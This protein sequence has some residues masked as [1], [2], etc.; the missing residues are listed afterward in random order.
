MD[1]LTEYC[2][3]HDVSVIGLTETWLRNEV[4]DEEVCI[5]GFNIFRSDRK[6]RTNPDFPHGGV[7]FYVKEDLLVEHVSKFT[8]GVC[9]ALVM[10]IRNHDV[11]LGVVYRPP[12]TLPAVFQEAASFITE[13]FEAMSTTSPVSTTLLMG[14]FNIPKTTT[15]WQT[16]DHGLIPNCTEKRDDDFR[17]FEIILKMT[18]NCFQS[19]IVPTATRGES[20]LDLMFIEDINTVQDVSTSVTA[21]SDHELI[22]L[23][24]NIGSPILRPCQDG[25]KEAIPDIAKFD[26]KRANWDL[27]RH[28]LLES[29]VVE[30]IKETD[31]VASGFTVLVDV[32]TKACKA[33][34]VPPKKTS[35][36]FREIPEKRRKLF[37]KKCKL[38][39]QLRNQPYETLRMSA[40][41]KRMRGID[42]LIHR[43]L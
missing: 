9:E 35:G 13:K 8:N 12:K 23:Q 22:L 10:S 20:F 30:S 4:K 7:A 6:S 1:F 14:D 28:E 38:S 26:F 41:K 36:K 11:N 40:L 17:S 31:S 19:Q 33:A 27:L 32:I 42:S 34:Q 29:D 2:I 43:A 21:V 37:R 16:T 15:T 3:V 39:K 24:T 5:P 18:A 25:E